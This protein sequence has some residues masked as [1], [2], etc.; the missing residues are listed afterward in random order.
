ME[1][2]RNYLESMFKS[3]GNSPQVLR[4]KEELFSMMEDKYNELKSQGISENG[5]VGQVISEFGNLSEVSQILGI[6]EELEGYPLVTKSIAESVVDAYHHYFPKLAW[7]IF[8]IISST[9]FMFVLMSLAEISWSG[10]NENIAVG[11]SLFIIITVVSL[12]VLLIISSST[13]LKEFEYI[14]EEP[15]KLEE[16]AAI[17]INDLEKQDRDH[18]IKN[19]GLSVVLIILSSLP[20]ILTAL[21]E[22][23]LFIFLS[24][25][26]FMVFL[27]LFKDTR[28]F[29]INVVLLLIFGLILYQTKDVTNEDV[30]IL[31]ALSITILMISSAVFNLIKNNTINHVAPMLLQ[32]DEYRIE[33]KTNNY[34]EM[35]SGVYWTIATAIYLAWSFI[36]YDW[37]LTWIVWPIAG[38]IYGGLSSY[39]EYKVKNNRY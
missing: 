36:T 31:Q 29:I 5:A 17:Y 4:A 2:I 23:N 20:L 11:I 18:Y 3:L 6:S 1:A 26:L 34:L 19:L 37:H 21:L 30:L 22:T 12:A 9:T 15:F 27:V 8:A 14:R 32:K 38:V 13:K 25:I 10:I 35:I 24:M 39:L 33:A 7:A 28:L 16:S